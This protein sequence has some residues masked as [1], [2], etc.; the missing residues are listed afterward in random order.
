MR[1]NLGNNG[2]CGY[3]AFGTAVI[4][5]IEEKTLS[6]EQKF[7]LRHL[8]G[9]ESTVEI[10]STASISY[11]DKLLDAKRKKP[12]K[13]F[14]NLAWI[15][16]TSNLAERLFTKVKFVFTDYRKSLPPVNLEAQIFPR[17]DKN[18]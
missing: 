12:N 15:P 7:E 11:A 1:N 13:E 10:V 9:T 16:P 8:A 2:I 18:F 6:T 5:A 4:C 14:G 17:A 3:P